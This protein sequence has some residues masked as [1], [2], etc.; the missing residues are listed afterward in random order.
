MDYLIVPHR[1]LAWKGFNNEPLA[2]HLSVRKGCTEIMYEL[3][4][5]FFL[6]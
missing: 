4:K 5:S 6:F 3:S 2:S 1:V